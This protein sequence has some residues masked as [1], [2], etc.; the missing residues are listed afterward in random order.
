MEGVQHNTYDVEFYGPNPLCGIYY[1]GA[2]R[3]AEEMAQAAGDSPLPQR[4]AFQTGKQ[5]IDANLFNGEF[6]VQK[7]RGFSQR[8]VAKNL[9]S[10]MGSENTESPEYQV[11]D[12]CLVDQLIGQYLTE[13][14]GLGAAVSAQK[15][16]RTLQSIY[17]YN[18]KPTLAAAR[19]CASERTPSTTKPPSSS[20]TTEKPA[21][22]HS[23]P[24]L[25]RSL[26]R[27]GVLS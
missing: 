4:K 27:P 18:Y 3:A 19:Q 25:R 1:L 14:G 26:D 13:F 24:L 23:V 5:W 16:R 22:A 21:P 17:K 6:Y 10:D 11:G 8:S 12:G 2:L 7:V 15:I 9:R 20:A